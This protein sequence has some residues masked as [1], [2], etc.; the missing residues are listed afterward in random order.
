MERDNARVITLAPG[1]GVTNVSFEEAFGEYSNASGKFAKKRAERVEARQE[2]KRDIKAARTATKVAKQENKAAKKT[3][4]IE[5]RGAVQQSRIGKRTN[6]QTSRIGKRTNATQLRQEKR[7][8]KDGPQDPA[9]EQEQLPVDNQTEQPTDN[10]GSQ[11]SDNSTS[12]SPAFQEG[13][14]IGNVPAYDED[15]PLEDD[16]PED[17]QAGEEEEESFDGTPSKELVDLANKIEW[18]KKFVALKTAEKTELE[19]QGQPTKEVQAIILDRLDRISGL[20]GEISNFVNFEGEYASADGTPSV[21]EK[22]KRFG[23]VSKAREMARK[24]YS[25]LSARRRAI[26]QHG[27][28][29][30][31]VDAE[32]SPSFGP[33]KI[34]VPGKSNAEGEFTE[35][36]TDDGPKPTVLELTS[37]A[38]GLNVSGSKINWTGIVI[39]LA[40]AGVA[41]YGLNKFKVL[42]K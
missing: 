16:A 23:Q 24:N 35:V 30:T 7:A 19:K 4:K 11:Y 40:I 20:E 8:I 27:G 25:G 32:L 29:E 9:L 41:I 5:K 22:G 2:A 13:P 37:S 42:S 38:N 21:T 33:N 14:E 1:N 28:A 34:V 3:A 10:G 18:N 12:N 17:D 15:A 39:G 6:A 31:P 26:K 36:T